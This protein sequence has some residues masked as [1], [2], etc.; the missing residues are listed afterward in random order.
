[1]D[2]NKADDNCCGIA[3]LL[4]IEPRILEIGDEIS[5]DI[6][7]IPSSCGVGPSEF[8]KST[9]EIP[10]EEISKP[11]H[12]EH[13]CPHAAAGK[14]DSF[15]SG[16]RSS[17]GKTYRVLYGRVSGTNRW[18]E[19]SYR[20]PKDEWSAESARAHCKAHQGM[21]FESAKKSVDDE[22]T[23]NSVGSATI[24]VKKTDPLRH[25]VYG[26]VLEPGVP[27]LQKDIEHPE[28]VEKSA[29]RYMAKMWG[30]RQPTMVGS[31]HSYPI[32]KAIPVESFIAPCDF[33]YDGTP[34]DEDHL[35]KKG[36]WVVV[37]L[38]EDDDEFESVKNGTY[39]GYSMQGVGNRRK[40]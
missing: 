8:F 4:D 33:Y 18:E 27:D 14:F 32:Q 16:S 1:M 24:S 30:D 20:Y 2:T 11:Y 15:R 31:E 19:A 29:H 40:L 7:E 37:T 35:V 39:R 21:A 26:I 34:H 23:K 12:N 10:L 38:V 28:E 3:H 6:L 22:A 36:S 9:S 25:L 5:I 13:A 17:G